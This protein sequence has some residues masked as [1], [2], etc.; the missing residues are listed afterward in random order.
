MKAEDLFRSLK[1]GDVGQ[2]YFLYGDDDFLKDASL[3][4]LKEVALTGAIADFN[5]DLFRAGEVNMSNLMSALATLPV[6]ASRRLVVLKDADK[7]KADEQET[8]LSYLK[9]PSPSTTLVMSGKDVDKRK[10]FFSVIKEKGNL[11]DHSHPYEREMPKWIKWVAKKKGVEISNEAAR[12][13]VDIVG[14]DLASVANELEKAS[15]YT[16]DR[17]K[18]V[19]LEAIE[20]VTIDMRAR[21]VF[22]LID[23]LGTKNLKK[24]LKNLKR[25]LDDGE[26]PLMILS[27]IVRQLRLIWTGLDIMKNG[28]GEGEVR[29]KIKLPPFVFKG[30]L[31]QVKLFKEDELRSA[32]ESLFDL[33]LKF[34]SSPVNKERALELLIFKLCS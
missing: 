27:M 32:Y 25:L 8:L 12:Y 3:E 19:E 31:K 7:L 13:L 20:A 14:T 11:V 21:T 28:G 4:K 16:G 24:S 17:S 1:N 5:Y 15:I 23:A 9:D 33:D 30:Y 22:Q 6:M 10:T 34:K 29:K 2:I 18:R 26:S